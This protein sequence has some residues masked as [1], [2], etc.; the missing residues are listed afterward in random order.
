MPESSQ[1]PTWSSV[2]TYLLGI[3]TAVIP[4]LVRHWLD[5]KKISKEAEES[6]AR[7]DLTRASVTSLHIRDS[8]ATGEG[9]SKMLATLIEA[10]DTIKDLQAR[11][12]EL[13]QDAIAHRIAR[14]DLRKAKGLLDAHGIKFSEADK[15]VSK[16]K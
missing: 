3:L 8:I 5:R 9:V 6:E 1:L 15:S 13:E 10:G 2:F 4:L 11:V 14:Y 12:F 16:R 7:A